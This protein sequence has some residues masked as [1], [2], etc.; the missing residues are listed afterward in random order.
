MVYNPYANYQ[1]MFAMPNFQPAQ[2]LQQPVQQP[3]IQTIQ[4]T[5][6]NVQCFFVN[7]KQGLQ[8]MQIEPNTVY[9]GINKQAK[10]IY[11]RAW[12]NNGVIE[13][14]TYSVAEVKSETSELQKIA[15]RLKAIEEMLN[16]RN[17]TNANAASNVGNVAKQ[18]GDV[19]I[20]PNDE[21]K[22]VRRPNTNLA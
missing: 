18:S 14:E 17:F 15:D 19:A 4:P 3:T 20:Q 21:R 11:T 16:E 2:P 13:T 9:I 7:D 10:E 1:P 5:N 12:N 8:N 22:G 6:P